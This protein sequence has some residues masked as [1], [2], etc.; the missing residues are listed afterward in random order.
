M[1]GS[2]T[3]ADYDTLDLWLNKIMGI[4]KFKRISENPNIYV[5]KENLKKKLP[6]FWSGSLEHKCTQG[7]PGRKNQQEF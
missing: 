1:T 7:R 5:S 3:A 4:Q 2:D 6:W